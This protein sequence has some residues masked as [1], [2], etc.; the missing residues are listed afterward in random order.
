ME[1]PT[2]LYPIEEYD[3]CQ[4]F[5]EKHKAYMAAIIS[6]VEPKIFSQAME[7]ERWRNAMGGEIDAQEINRTW[8]IEDLPK[9]KCAIGFKWVYKLKFNSDGSL[10]RHKARLVTLGSKQIEGE[11]YGETFAPVAKIGTVRM[12]LDTTVKHKWEV[13]KMDVHNAFLHE[14]LDEE[15]Y[16]KLPPGFTSADPSKVCRLRKSLYGLKQAPRC[17]F[18]KLSTALKKYDF[19]QCFADYS[20]FTYHR[21]RIRINV[22]IYVD[23]IIITGSSE[24]KNESFKEYLSTCFHMKDLGDLK[25][26]LGIEVAKN[27]IGIYLCQR[28]YALNIIVETGLLGA[29]PVSFP[30]EHNH[31]LSLSKTLLLSNPEP[32]K[33]LIGHLIYLGVTRPDLA[34]CVHVL[35]QFMQAPRDAHWQ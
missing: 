2:I 15:V 11:D 18:A 24:K 19:E 6:A 21:D 31:Q 23:D 35:A 28:K 7:Y 34:Y 9:G 12:F 33:R 30:L 32:Y 13:H 10:K 16:M 27:S 1:S 17:W 26:F 5:L 4:R 29:K 14:D 8:T 22:L 20:L 3:D 25:Y